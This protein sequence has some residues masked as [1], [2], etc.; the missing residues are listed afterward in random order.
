MLT[1]RSKVFSQSVPYD[2]GQPLASLLRSVVSI[3][4]FSRSYDMLLCALSAQRD[5][6][7]SKK[8][9]SSEERTTSWCDDTGGTSFFK[10]WEIFSATKL[11]IALPLQITAFWCN[12][13]FFIKNQTYF[14]LIA[15]MF[16]FN[17]A[18]DLAIFSLKLSALLG[19]IRKFNDIN[20]ACSKVSRKKLLL[21][22]NAHSSSFMN[23]VVFSK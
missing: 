3:A 14:P 18:L 16:I 20:I 2:V 8:D 11:F 4:S 22:C 6:C 1:I 17:E 9:S 23:F 10:I 12:R 7:L 13:R 5:K 21:L 15:K 19:S